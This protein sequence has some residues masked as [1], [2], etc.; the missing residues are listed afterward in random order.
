MEDCSQPT[1]GQ[2]KY[3][4]QNLAKSKL[5]ILAIAAIF[6]LAVDQLT[7]AWIVANVAGGPPI[8]LISGFAR[9]RYAENTGAAFGFL[10]GW[11]GL[12]S[13][14]AIVII[15]VIVLMAS[16][17]SANPLGMIALGLVTGGA[18]GNLT[19]RLR[20][21]YVVDFM[22]VFGPRIS[23]NNVNYTF[24]LFNLAD[25]A[26]T[27]G[28]ILLMAT[29]LFAKESSPITDDGLATATAGGAEGG[30]SGSPAGDARS[31]NSAL[32]ATTPVGWASLLVMVAG[33]FL[34]AFR[35]ASRRS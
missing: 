27:I 20:L 6:A 35:Q 23:I 1:T 16:K 4:K 2:L 3:M 25:T 17:I 14:A 5:H 7:K 13:F 18:L 19:D 21:G 12:L 26:I 10:K 8:T 9:L 22:D 33:L 24:P 15:V 31:F 28:A 11:T 30:P 34:M 29:L 32:K